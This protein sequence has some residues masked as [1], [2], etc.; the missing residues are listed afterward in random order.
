MPKREVHVSLPE[1]ETRVQLK[2][3]PERD[4]G[5]ST[6]KHE[7]RVRKQ[8]ILICYLRVLTQRREICGQPQVAKNNAE[9]G[10][11]HPHGFEVSSSDTPV[12]DLGD[13]LTRKWSVH[14]IAPQCCCERLIMTVLSGVP[15]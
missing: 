9:Q 4:L 8:S 3:T 2:P 10:N 11:P 6:L 15:L 7:T 1:D 14:Q 13:Y 12:T 5:V